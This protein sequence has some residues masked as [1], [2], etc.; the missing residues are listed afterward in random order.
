MLRGLAARQRSTGGAAVPPDRSSP[1]WDGSSV[2]Q[3]VWLHILGMVGS[4][5]DYA[6][7]M[8]VSRGMAAVARDPRLW[9]AECAR[10][11]VKIARGGAVADYYAVYRAQVVKWRRLSRPAAS[12]ARRVFRMSVGVR[13]APSRDPGGTTY[14]TDKAEYERTSWAGVDRRGRVAADTPVVPPAPQPK[15]APARGRGLKPSHKNNKKRP[16]AKAPPRQ[17][18]LRAREHEEVLQKQRRAAAA[19]Q[20]KRQRRLRAARVKGAAI[21]AVGVGRSSA[22]GRP[23]LKLVDEPGRQ[24]VVEGLTSEPNR[25]FWIDGPVLGPAASQ[26]D[27]HL[28]VGSRVASEIAGGESGALLLYGQTGSGKTFTATG[29]LELALRRVEQAACAQRAEPAAAGAAYRAP[30]LSDSQARARIVASAASRWSG[31][32]ALPPAAGLIPRIMSDL[33]ASLRAE[34]DQLEFRM[35]V[36]YVEVYQEAVYD[37]LRNGT[38]LGRRGHPP[39]GGAARRRVRTL[40][41]ALRALCD[42]QRQRRTASTR[43]NARSSRSHAV[44]TVR[45]K[46][47]TKLHP[48]LP[49]VFSVY[50]L[51][52]LAGS[53]RQRRLGAAGRV[54]EEL[55]GINKSLS[56][57]ERCVNSLTDGR[58]VGHVPTRDSTLTELLASALAGAHRA[59]LLVTCSSDR[60]DLAET[61]STLRFAERAG[62]MSLSLRRQIKEARAALIALR[63]EFEGEGLDSE[64]FTKRERWKRAARAHKALVDQMDRLRDEKATELR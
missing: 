37:L 60:A 51:V 42:G 50:H 58:S 52:D 62:R 34:G 54:F 24:V 53:E 8:G 13:M 28:R 61:L 39:G 19:W 21:M 20:R 10:E 7:L 31:Q 11:G 44:L 25:I 47:R 15:A 63:L 23:E 32:L 2:P 35:T 48:R 45:L 38:K 59:R 36:S 55:C 5:R 57:L 64:E 43:M 30:R 16:P 22:N 4:A 3:D 9:R 33:L 40:E 14:T 41:D 12:R 27:V 1:A 6:A 26:A 46:Q 17:L 29:S 18:T 49:P 56:A